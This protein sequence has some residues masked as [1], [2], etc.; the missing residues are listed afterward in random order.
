MISLPRSS[1]DSESVPL[2]SYLLAKRLEKSSTKQHDVESVQVCWRPGRKKETVRRDIDTNKQQRPLPRVKNINTNPRSHQE[3]QQRERS[4]QG[5]AGF[6]KMNHRRC[7]TH[8]QPLAAPLAKPG[9]WLTCAATVTMKTNGLC[10]SWR[11]PGSA[12]RVCWC[13]SWRFPFV[14][15]GSPRI[16]PAS[17]S[18]RIAIRA[19]SSRS[20]QRSHG[21]PSS[22]PRPSVKSVAL[23]GG[24]G[25]AGRS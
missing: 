12:G 8:V 22:R 2:L 24:V 14:P 11:P 18:I 20:S 3:I 1:P 23:K 15:L 19:M 4:F 6:G 7:T 5:G 9:V 17:I 25:S 10:L 16:D 21:R 13:F